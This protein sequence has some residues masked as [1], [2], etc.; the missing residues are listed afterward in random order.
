MD[1]KLI[2]REKQFV[3]IVD[4]EYDLAH[5]FKEALSQIESIDPIAFTDPVVALEHFR[6]NHKDYAVV[7]S[8]YRMPGMTGDDLLNNIKEINPSVTRI[9]ISAFDVYDRVFDNCQYVDQFLRKPVKMADL[10]YNV[11]KHIKNIVNEPS[12]Q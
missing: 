4:D 2:S 7:I 12:L 3:A 8:D 6:V 10:I 11:K 5:L 1:D 9:M